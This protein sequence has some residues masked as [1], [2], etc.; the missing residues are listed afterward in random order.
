MRYII[1]MIITGLAVGCSAKDEQK[2]E[3]L[4]KVK[5]LELDVKHI[6]EED[7]FFLLPKSGWL[8]NKSYEAPETELFQ[9]L[10]IEVSVDSLVSIWSKPAKKDIH[11]SIKL[12]QPIPKID[13]RVYVVKK[14]NSAY[15]IFKEN[16]I[17]HYVESDKNTL[18]CNQYYLP[19]AAKEIE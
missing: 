1:F 5:A 6:Q 16:F 13:K 8:K 2:R 19:D 9:K 12:I 18:I 3:S 14:P 4:E 10:G 11:A 15:V 17:L 7:L